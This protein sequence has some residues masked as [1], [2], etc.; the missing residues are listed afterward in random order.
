MYSDRL[1]SFRTILI[2]LSSLPWCFEIR[3][4]VAACGVIAKIFF[5]IRFTMPLKFCLQ[6]NLRLL[7]TLFAP[8][9]RYTSEFWWRK[10]YLLLL[11]CVLFQRLWLVA[12]LMVVAQNLKPVAGCMFKG[13]KVWI[14]AGRKWKSAIIC[15]MGVRV[16]PSTMNPIVAC[17]CE[18]EVRNRQKFICH[19]H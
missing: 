16:R 12:S 14:R 5:E 7:T 15:E 13:P 10:S 19:S 17:W 9:I 8:R 4:L 2:G 6:T 11:S 18:H 3:F 1:F